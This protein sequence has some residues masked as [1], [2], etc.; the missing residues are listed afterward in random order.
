MAVYS[1]YS[2]SQS[3]L[4]GI[5]KY[6]QHFA[7]IGSGGEK[8]SRLENCLTRKSI[9]IYLYS[10]YCLRA[11]FWMLFSVIALYEFCG[12]KNNHHNVNLVRSHESDRWI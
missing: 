3:I 10:I 6:S 7:L 9:G 11:S 5:L 12:I 8:L 4:I 1:I 2:L